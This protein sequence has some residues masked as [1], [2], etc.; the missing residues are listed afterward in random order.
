LS[1]RKLERTSG[2]GKPSQSISV[3]AADS[4]A[5]RALAV[6]LPPAFVDRAQLGSYDET[7][8]TE[9]EVAAMQAN[10][11]TGQE[12]STRSSVPVGVLSIALALSGASALCAPLAVTPAGTL[13]DSLAPYPITM[14]WDF[15]LDRSY[16]VTALD[17][18][19]NGLPYADSHQVGLWSAEAATGYPIGT[20]IATVTFS[21]GT[22]GIANGPYRSLPISPI[23]LNPG[24]YEVGAFVSG[25]TGSSDPYLFGQ[26]SY[27]LLPGITF[28]GGHVDTGGAFTYP[29]GSF[30]VSGNFAANFEGTAAPVPEPGIAALLLWGLIGLAAMGGK[31]I[32]LSSCRRTCETAPTPHRP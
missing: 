21:A 19:S 7:R 22:S 2:Y 9:R 31:P 30:F 27:S 6:A 17:F 28:V 4:G 26:S 20:L 18:Y 13:T 12:T 1:Q 3:D 8:K 11:K 14:A 23:M 25:G 5:A 24:H 15:G 10:L 29:G 32:A 16:Q